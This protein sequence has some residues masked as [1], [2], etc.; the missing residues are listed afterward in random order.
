MLE[1]DEEGL[2]ARLFPTPGA[3]RSEWVAQLDEEARD[4]ATLSETDEVPAGSVQRQVSTAMDLLPT[5]AALCGAAPPAE[6]KLDGHDVS[7]LWRGEPG[8]ASPTEHFLYYKPRGELAGVRRGPWK[9]LLDKSELYHL[10][11][12]PRENWNVAKKHPDLVTELQQLALD[13]DDEITTN[14][15]PTRKVQALRFDPTKPQK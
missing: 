5:L 4:V 12:D 8:A 15:R 9:L 7:A 6:R 13:L 10:E 3:L 11:R 14:A 1:L 2:V